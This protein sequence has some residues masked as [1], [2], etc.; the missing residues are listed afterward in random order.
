MKKEKKGKRKTRMI[1]TEKN[2]EK[3]RKKERKKER[4]GRT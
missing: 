1:K 3:E 4:T 2:T